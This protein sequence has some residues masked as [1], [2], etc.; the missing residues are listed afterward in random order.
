MVTSASYP[1]LASPVALGPLE[2]RNR[3]VL[4]PHG[5]AFAVSHLP[6]PRHVEYYRARARGGVAMIC[7]ESAFVSR[8]GFPSGPLVCASDP[9]A[10][11]GYSA[12]ADA[13]H[14]EG[15]VIQ[16]QLAHFGN[17]GDVRATR[18]PLIGPSHLSDPVIRQPCVVMSK[19]DMARVVDDFVAGARNF[20]AAGFDSVELKIGHDGLLRQFLSPLTNDRDDE[21]GGSVANRLRYPLEVSA[22]VREAIGPELGL[23]L[24]LCLDE[25]YPGGYGLPEGLEFARAFAASGFFTHLTPTYGVYGSQEQIIAPMTF[26][27]GYA[28]YAFAAA[29]KTSGLPVIA[30][31]MIRSPEYAERV[32]SDPGV[33][34]VGMARELMADPEWATKVISGRAS[35]VRPC[36]ACN[37]L[38]IGNTFIP[39]PLSCTVNP[40]AGHGERRAKVSAAQGRLV[41]VGGGPAGLEAARTAAED[42][43]EV[44]LLEGTER[45][46]GLL[47]LA[48]DTGRR[49]GWKRYLS[50]LESELVRLGVEL[51]FGVEATAADVRRLEPAWV[52]LA[53]GSRAIPPPIEGVISIETFLQEPTA[54]DHVV[55]A[56]MGLDGMP[57]WSSAL[58][59]ASRGAQHVTLVTP[60]PSIAADLEPS[61]FVDLYRDL[62]QAGVRFHRDHTVIG[63]TDSTVSTRQVHTGEVTNLP[64]DVLVGCSPRQS[65]GAALADDLRPHYPVCVVGDALLPRDASA[66]VREGQDA[67]R[68]LVGLTA[69][70][71]TT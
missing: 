33:A 67:V 69:G 39:L 27:E 63:F 38:C 68:T 71:G 25:V 53:C 37:Q 18:R 66:A 41:V 35:Q 50:W 1:L 24:R 7:V 44:V 11:P 65:I 51:C 16:G 43:F 5:T 52:V 47:A 23:S 57:L 54:T 12:I 19:A 14:A 8:D 55:L 32:L 28:E 45:A 2:L 56:D 40:H 20:K 36:T 6:S 42:G 49:T 15:A 64:A 62:C 4:L 9:A 58:E 70:D 29:T 22:A 17:Q 34:A 48:G 13:V 10:L 31:G 59:A 46:G 26:P 60:A 3:V 21:Y 30:V 61:T